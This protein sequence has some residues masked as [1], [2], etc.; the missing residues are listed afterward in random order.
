VVDLRGC[1]PAVLETLVE[2]YPYVTH[3]RGHTEWLCG[4]APMKHKVYKFLLEGLIA[5]YL[6]GERS[7]AAISGKIHIRN[8]AEAPPGV[9]GV[10][11]LGQGPLAWRCVYNSGCVLLILG[12]GQRVLL[13]PTLLEFVEEF[14]YPLPI[15][16]VVGRVIFL[17]GEHLLLEDRGL[18]EL[19]KAP[20]LSALISLV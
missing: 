1:D 4:A 15:G 8:Q 6:R 3:A 2:P 5:I 12:S 16:G 17:H 14:L 11:T 10:V 18:G 19:V 9:Q 7:P 13:V 20:L